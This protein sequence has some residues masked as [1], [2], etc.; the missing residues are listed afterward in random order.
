MY[1]QKAASLKN[2]KAINNLAIFYEYGI[3]F[4]VDEEKAYNM[5]LEASKYNNKR[6]VMNVARYYDQGKFVEVLK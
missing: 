3:G 6:A 5:Y 2:P 1:Y 4:E